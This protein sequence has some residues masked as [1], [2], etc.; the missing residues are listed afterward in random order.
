V[1]V[2]TR[3]LLRASSVVLAGVFA[4][5]ELEPG[6]TGTCQ[7]PVALTVGTFTRAE[8]YHDDCRGPDISGDIFT[9]APMTQANVM[10]SV[11]PEGTFT[12]RLQIYRGTYGDA[13]PP[14]VGEVS[15]YPGEALS[16]RVFLAPGSYFLVAGTATRQRETYRMT[17]GAV[18]GADCFVWSFLTPGVSVDGSVG[19]EDCQ[20]I[21]TI[22]RESFEMWRD[23]GD[24]VN[25]TVIADSTGFFQFG[26]S[27]CESLVVF[28]QALA[29]GDS[30]T[31]GHKAP[32]RRPYRASFRRDVGLDGT[33]TYRLRFH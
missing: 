31:F 21:N 2:A 9:F 28:A 18:A 23:V 29:A 22:I 33:G 19:F 14:L 6:R 20:V 30:V 12:P 5:C 13:N 25:V 7:A 26:E 24:S 11:V 32:R 16:A 4:S 27:C 3:R 17:T 10:F 1:I 15:G 8:S